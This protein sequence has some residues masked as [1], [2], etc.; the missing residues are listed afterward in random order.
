M[1][2]VSCSSKVQILFIFNVPK[3][4]LKFLKLPMCLWVTHSSRAIFQR[5]IEHI[6]N[7]IVNFK[8]RYS[9]NTLNTLNHLTNASI[10]T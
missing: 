3:G 5:K 6:L 2:S 7:R 4:L 9:G 10:I 1:P 8:N